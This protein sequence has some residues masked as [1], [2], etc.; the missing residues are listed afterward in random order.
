MKDD[1]QNYQEFVADGTP[2]L[3]LLTKKFENRKRWQPL[4]PNEIRSFIPGTILE[5][6][7]EPGQE[8]K[9]GQ[10]L[11]LLEA[12]KMQTRTEMPVDGVIK[13]VNVRKGDKV[14]KNMVLIVIQ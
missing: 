2:Y 8:V 7:V 3:T 13:E 9:E 11:V 5:V 10:P 12:M 4:D 1:I 14:P 6:Y